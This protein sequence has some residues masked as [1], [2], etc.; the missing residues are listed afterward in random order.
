MIQMP[1]TPGACTQ[2]VVSVPFGDCSGLCSQAAGTTTYAWVP[3]PFRACSL[4]PPLALCPQ[5]HYRMTTYA[6]TTCLIV[7]SQGRITQ[8]S[9]NERTDIDHQRTEQATGH[10]LVCSVPFALLLALLAGPSAPPHTHSTRAA[11]GEQPCCGNPAYNPNREM[12]TAGEVLA[13]RG[14]TPLM[15]QGTDRPGKGAPEKAR[16]AA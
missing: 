7:Q 10:G 16:T 15:N 13:I 3:L 14:W 12:L 9:A 8:M 2:T 1:G 5:L 4:P 11:C 6:R